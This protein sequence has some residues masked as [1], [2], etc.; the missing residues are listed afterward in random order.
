MESGHF[1]ANLSAMPELAPTDFLVEYES[2]FLCPVC[3]Y[4]GTFKGNHYADNE[5]GCIAT[6]ICSCC[7]F[8]PGFDDNPAAL[9]GS[10]R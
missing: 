5:G 6:G 10:G 1:D 7:F 4:D 2:A 9:K 8:E 3:G